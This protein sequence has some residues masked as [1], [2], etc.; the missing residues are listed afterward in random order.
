MPVTGG[1]SGYK[2][3]TLRLSDMISVNVQLIVNASVVLVVKVV[4]VAYPRSTC[5]LT[6]LTELTPSPKYGLTVL[7]VS[8]SSTAAP[9]MLM[10][11]PQ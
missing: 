8:P 5:L 1:R 3:H 6:A 10:T 11:G 4:I 7:M 2:V 9:P